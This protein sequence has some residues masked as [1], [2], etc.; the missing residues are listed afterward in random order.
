MCV[1][2]NERNFVVKAVSMLSSRGSGLMEQFPQSEGE[3]ALQT[4]QAIDN[5]GYIT[6]IPMQDGIPTVDVVTG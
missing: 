2:H 6:N 1:S 5:G 3:A 4:R